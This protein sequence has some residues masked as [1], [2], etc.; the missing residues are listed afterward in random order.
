M[1]PTSQHALLLHLAHLLDHFFMLIFP[2]AVLA[3]WGLVAAVMLPRIG[4]T[5]TAAAPASSRA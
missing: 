5:P 2:S 4:E 3:R 1:G